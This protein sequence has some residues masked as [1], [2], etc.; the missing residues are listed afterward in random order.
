MLHNYRSVTF[1]RLIAEN[2]WQATANTAKMIVLGAPSYLVP[3]RCYTRTMV[4]IVTAQY[5]VYKCTIIYC[6]CIVTIVERAL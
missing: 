4:A 5:S 2:L 1:Y 3:A 6:A